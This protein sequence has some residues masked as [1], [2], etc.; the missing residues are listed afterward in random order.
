[1]LRDQKMWRTQQNIIVAVRHITLY[2]CSGMWRDATTKI[3]HVVHCY[4][5]CEN[6]N[7]L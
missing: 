2:S 1:M 7:W 6:L 5:F 4:N 3:I